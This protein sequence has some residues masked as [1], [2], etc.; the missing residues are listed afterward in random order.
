MVG[1]CIVEAVDD[2]K[3]CQMVQISVLDGTLHDS[4]E[5]MQD[6]GFVSRPKAGA[7]AVVLSVGGTQSHRI[8]VAM[9]DRKSR[10]SGL[11]EGEAALHDDQQQFIHIMRDKILIKSPLKITI[12]APTVEVTADHVTVASNDVNLGGAG[13]AAVA[14]VGDPVVGGVI[15]AGSAKVK[16][17]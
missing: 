15:T 11:A 12:E 7:E 17:V 10:K 4:V 5:R 9:V 14:R 3:L 6:Y 1:R 13:G 2:E 8:V 16:A